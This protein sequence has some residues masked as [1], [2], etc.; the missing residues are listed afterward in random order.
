MKQLGQIKNHHFFKFYLYYNNPKMISPFFLSFWK[1]IIQ[2]PVFLTDS[3]FNSYSN[4]YLEFNK[5][6]LESVLFRLSVYWKFYVPWVQMFHQLQ[7]HKMSPSL[8]TNSPGISLGWSYHHWNRKSLFYKIHFTE[9]SFKFVGDFYTWVPCLN[10]IFLSPLLSSC[11]L[12]H[13]LSSQ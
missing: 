13:H 6:I 12:T 8:V 5:G 9:Q 4:H 10:S 11:P 2:A 7:T 3:V 1:L